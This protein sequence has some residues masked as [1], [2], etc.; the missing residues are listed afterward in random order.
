MSIGRTESRSS[1]TSVSRSTSSTE[2][3]KPAELVKPDQK[4]ASRLADRN[5]D[6]FEEPIE[7]ANNTMT[8]S[9]W[10]AE[11]GLYGVEATKTNA[12]KNGVS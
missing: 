12:T 10:A 4:L 7:V 5:R 8:P 1:S 6:A 11:R 3:A 9:Q 2:T